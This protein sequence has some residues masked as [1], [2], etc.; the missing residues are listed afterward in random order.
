M[1]SLELANFF[2]CSY[3]WHVVRSSDRPVR[4]PNGLIKPAAN[5]R[6]HA[7]LGTWPGLN[8]QS[9][10]CIE[11]AGGGGGGG[12]TAIGIEAWPGLKDTQPVQIRLV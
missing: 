5:S 11:N 6:R 7:E 12:G 1:D 2:F 8:Y 3:A 9:W 4:L 10:I